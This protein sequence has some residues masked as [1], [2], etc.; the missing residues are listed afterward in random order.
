MFVI[1][2]PSLLISVIKR[3][4]WEYASTCQITFKKFSLKVR[5]VPTPTA[6]F[7]KGSELKKVA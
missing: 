2:A 7:Q 3:V 1:H 6:I 4:H 5:P